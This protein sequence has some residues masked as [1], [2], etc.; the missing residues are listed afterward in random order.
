ERVFAV[1]NLFEE[2]EEEESEI[3]E[4]P[5]L[6]E[7]EKGKSENIIR[8]AHD[9]KIPNVSGK[10]GTTLATAKK[11]NEGLVLDE[12]EIQEGRVPDVRGMGA[13]DAIFILEN[14]GLRVKIKGVGKVKTQSMLPGSGFS[15]GAYVYLTL[16]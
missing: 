3:P 10:P 5:V 7:V 8:I 13:S 11:V 16:G 1:R 9:L 6:P 15:R 14:A 4:A 12:I 2:T